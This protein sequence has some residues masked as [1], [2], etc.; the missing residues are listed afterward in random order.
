[1]YAEIAKSRFKYAESV[2]KIPVIGKVEKAN[3]IGNIL[4]SYE[5]YVEH[6]CF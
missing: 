3:Y 2:R 6:R 5:Q 4:R 1:M